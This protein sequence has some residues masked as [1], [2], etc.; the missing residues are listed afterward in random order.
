MALG[1]P[2]DPGPVTEHVG[3]LGF[4]WT[5]TVLPNVEGFYQWTF[6]ADGLRPCITS[7]F[8]AFAP[9]GATSTPT[10]TPLPTSTTGPTATPTNTVVPVPSLTTASSSGTCGSVVTVVGSNFGSPPS[11]VGTNVQLLGGPANAGTPKLLNLI[12]GSNTQVTATLPSSGLVAGSYSLII[13]NNGGAS[14]TAP[15]TVTT[16]C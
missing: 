1:G 13:S 4:I 2:L 11:A 14:N 16:T 12:G 7:C 10:N 15:F 6:Y 3:P 5:W 9:V 8:N